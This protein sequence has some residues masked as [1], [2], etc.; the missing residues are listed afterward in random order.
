MKSTTS[1]LVIAKACAAAAAGLSTQGVALSTRVVN[2]NPVASPD[3]YPWMASLLWSPARPG[4]MTTTCGGTLVGPRW[5]LTAG[6]CVDPGSTGLGQEFPPGHTVAVGS[7]EPA[8]DKAAKTA[9]ALR[10]LAHPAF[11]HD[12]M[13]NDVALIQL[14]RAITLKHYAPLAPAD[15]ADPLPGTKMWVA[16]WG[17]LYNTGTDPTHLMEV[18]LPVMAREHCRQLYSGRPELITNSSICAAYSEGGRDSCNGDSGGPLLLVEAN[19]TATQVGL[20]SWGTGCASIGHPGLYTRVSSF[21][22]WIDATMA[23]VDRGD[24]ICGC[25]AKHLGNG[26]CNMLCYTEEC[27]WDGGDC[28]SNCSEGCTMAMLGN[29][30]CDP[31]CASDD[32]AVDNYACSGLCDARCLQSMVND[33]VCQPDCLTPSCQYDGRDCVKQFC[34]SACP[35]P[36][37][38]NGECNP[39][40]YN[41]KCEHDG[42]DCDAYKDSCALNCDQSTVGNGICNAACNVKECK[43]DGGDCDKYS[44][45]KAPLETVGDGTCNRHQNTSECLYD[46]GD[47]LFCAPRCSAS[48]TNNSVC[49]PACHNAACNWDGGLCDKLVG[50]DFC[51]VN[52][53][54]TQVGDGQC[55]EACFTE[56]CSWDADDCKDDRCNGDIGH[57][58]SKWTGDGYCQPDCALSGCNFEGGDCFNLET[59]RQC[60]PGCYPV[61]HRNNSVCDPECLNAA[62]NFDAPDCQPFLGCAPYCVESWIS[63]GVCDPECNTQG[64]LW[65]GFDCSAAS[66]T[67]AVGVMAILL[68][69]AWL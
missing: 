61:F 37:V 44:R 58:L 11:D 22:G 3:K 39:E 29:N 33:G 66:R 9:K 56:A 50:K 16:G 10:V 34:V 31:V 26:H 63:D 67:G 23:A 60:A 14:D 4:P 28:A 36:L 45:C 35:P 32:C 69:A 6:H 21:R 8:Q 48:M 68:A 2:G 7:L 53:R 25:P 18:K 1:L 30:V 55:D 41:D 54:K 19:G 17:L 12:R 43:Y 13:L 49:D 5:V 57:C 15:L 24:K 52:C 20:T 47:C 51:S 40:C 65:D 59:E 62:C 64:C 46:G 27:G 38:G 42:G